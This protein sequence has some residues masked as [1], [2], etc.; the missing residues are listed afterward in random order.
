[1]ENQL[2]KR[3]LSGSVSTMIGSVNNSG[4]HQPLLDMDVDPTL[5]HE[6]ELA[7]I[8]DP[9]FTVP[10]ARS[11]FIALLT[12]FSVGYS[13]GVVNA[14]ASVSFPGHT[15]AQWSF[16]VSVFA[17]G[18][19]IWENMSM[20]VF[21]YAFAIHFTGLAALLSGA[22]FGSMAGGKLAD[23]I[24]RKMTLLL[25]AVLQIIA[26]VVM[27][28]APNIIIFMVGR[29]IVG[30]SCGVGDNKVTCVQMRS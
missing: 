6:G 19:V 22:P 26:G 25:N 23:R 1:M 20:I 11:A 21:S 17:I 7:A 12:T 30:I 3:A 8:E 28:M 29:A 2:R 5:M 16:A 14:A 18:T 13:S 27:T 4:E 9:G 10:L 24:G 15:T